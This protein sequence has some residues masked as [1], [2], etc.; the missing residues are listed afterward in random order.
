MK[1]CVLIE[2]YVKNHLG[3]GGGEL[4]AQKISEYCANKGADVVVITTRKKGLSEFENINGVDV[5]RVKNL[6]IPY[7]LFRTY[8]YN[9]Y[10]KLKKLDRS[11]EFDIIHGHFPIVG[12]VPTYLSKVFLN[13]KTLVTI[14]GGDLLDYPEKDRFIFHLYRHFLGKIMRSMD[15]IHAVSKYTADLSKK[16]G[17]KNI[18]IIPNG[19]DTKIFNQNGDKINGFNDFYPLIIT[20]SRLVPKNGIDILIKTISKLKKEY[21]DIGCLIIGTGEQERYLQNLC[22]QLNATDNIKFL[23]F[24]E[25][26]KLPKYYCAADIF[27]RPSLQEGFGISFIEAM[28]CN[29]PVIGSKTGGIVDIINDKVDGVLVQ[30][31]DVD[32]LYNKIKLLIENE[33]LR[34]EIARN[35]YKKAIENYGWEIIGDKILKLYKKIVG[36]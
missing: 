3:D 7:F 35:G 28:A 22:H 34:K 11:Y 4:F 15:A 8:L 33:D 20:T 6:K 1:I 19:I 9:A 23:G 31:G 25:N 14:Q 36:G 10:L 2:Y 24:I 13:K 26:K 29:I 5:Y 30:P 21:S 32:D 17:G 18:N 16:Y 12:G 27:V